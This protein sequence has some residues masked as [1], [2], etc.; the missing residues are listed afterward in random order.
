MVDEEVS[1]NYQLLFELRS[2]VSTCTERFLRYTD[3]LAR[4]N[5]H[6]CKSCQALSQIDRE[7]MR[8]VPKDK[9]PYYVEL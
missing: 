2:S 1:G 7:E 8:I 5:E 9:G 6:N 4:R 3:C